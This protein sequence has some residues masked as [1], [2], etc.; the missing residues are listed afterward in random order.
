MD[1]IF[2]RH[3]TLEEANTFIPVVQK[4]F[5]LWFAI[6]DK[7]GNLQGTTIKISN[8]PAPKS[9]NGLNGSNG[10]RKNGSKSPEEGEST[11]VEEPVGPEDEI[12]I[13]NIIRKD[14]ARDGIVL[15]DINRGLIDFPSIRDGREVFLCWELAD[16]DEIQWYHEIDAGY[17]GRQPV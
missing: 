11:L 13:E 1:T 8:M 14:L 16:G 17:A 12:F 5:M 10:A 6:H 3:F 4:M 15:Q 9:L 2:P 7:S